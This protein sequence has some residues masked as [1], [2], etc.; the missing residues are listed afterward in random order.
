M[1]RAGGGSRGGGGG[2]RSSGG[3]SFGRSSGGHR[4]G[5]SRP[6]SSFSSPSRSSS[7]AGSSFSSFSS[8]SRSTSR[9]TSSYRP[10]VSPTPPRPPVAPPPY[11]PRSN[12]HGNGIGGYRAPIIRN[13]TIYN[14]SNPTPTYSS[15]T[16]SYSNSNGNYRNSN[17]SNNN[18]GAGC[19][20]SFIV[21][22]LIVAMLVALAS[23]G[24]NSAPSSTVNREKLET[25]IGFQNDCIVDEINWFD[26]V[27]QTSRRL[28]DFFN[29]TGVQPYI[30]LKDYDASLTTDEAKEEYANKWYEENIGN[31][32]TFLYF[33]FAEEDVD[34]DVGYMV[35]VSGTEIGPV[36]DSEAIDIFWSYLD[37]YWY[38]DMSTDDLFVTTFNKTANRIMDKST[39]A[40]DVGK[41]AV[42]FFGIGITGVIVLVIMKTKRKHDKEKAEETERILNTPLGNTSL[43]DL[44]DKY[45]NTD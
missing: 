14:N 10:P 28:Q 45:T 11:I 16:P 1:A 15:P 29:A 33:Y 26:N 7:R 5:S 37:S 41:Y 43:D 3:H 23:I 34:N 9:P 25:G 13:T 38:S 18:T 44:A 39:T 12:H 17:E 31:E 2:F 6:S 42:I 36:M 21:V 4:I 20:I 40:A 27:P 35:Y 22:V 32:A 8:P 19:L 30:V 24:S